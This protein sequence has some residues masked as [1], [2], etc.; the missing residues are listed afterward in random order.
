[1][2]SSLLRRL[3]PA[4]ASAALS[5]RRAAPDDMARVVTLLAAAAALTTALALPAAYLFA[6]YGRLDGRLETSATLHAAEVAEMARANPAFWEFEDLHVTAPSHNGR[7]AVPERRSVFGAN[8]KLVMEAGP[9][10]GLAWPVL[11]ASAPVREGERIIGQAEAARSF[12]EELIATGL[13]STSSVLLGG[14][15]FLTLRTVPLRMLRRALERTAYLAAHDMLTGLPNRAIFG[16]R[17]TQALALARRNGHTVA[18]LCLDLDRFKEV[19]DTLGHAAGDKLLREVSARLSA[20]LRESDTLARLGGDEFAV[21]QPQAAQPTDAESLARR[22]IAAIERPVGIDGHEV[23]V[24]VSVGIALA[25]PTREADPQRLMIEADLA[26]YQ[27]KERGRGDFCFF[28]PEMNARLMER[29]AMEADLRLALAEGH[30][31]LHYQPQVALPS[32]RV[33]G[34]EALLR[35]TRPGHGNVPPDRFIGVAEE[36]GL[37]AP[38]GAWAL[39]EAC[40]EAAGWPEHLGVAVNVSAVQFR[41][42]GLYEAVASALKASGL[43]PSRLELEITEGVLLNDTDDTLAMLNRLHALGVKIA[44][45]DFG[46]G[47]SSLGYLQKFTFDKIKIDRSFIQN[48]GND[49]NSAAIVRAVVGITRS[50]G[51]RANAEG[52]ENAGQADMLV[53]E[54]CGEVQ[55]YH[56][57]RPMP[58]GDFA[59]LVAG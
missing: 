18:V 45:D 14:L 16:D 47:Y 40:R 30:L 52:V 19:N 31:R 49:A 21:I 48:L 25:H 11:S 54:G 24:G 35:W 55:G 43:Q 28:S 36:T 57:G 29:R 51:V 44:M 32:G 53:A 1:M 27:V 26:L 22:I 13:V 10:Q 37:I 50:L 39:H 42:P 9:E 7:A 8:G 56:Y 38:I 34:A 6:A 12:R 58:P 5:A 3:V 15:I 20:C 4:W 41:L 2:L 33:I 59:R 23:T 17:L 46:T